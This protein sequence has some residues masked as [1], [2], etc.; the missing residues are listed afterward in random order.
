MLRTYL[1]SSPPTIA[2]LYA[3]TTK[4]KYISLQ[5]LCVNLIVGVRVHQYI[6]KMDLGTIK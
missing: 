1:F 5:R 4:S 6:T 3:G 2:F